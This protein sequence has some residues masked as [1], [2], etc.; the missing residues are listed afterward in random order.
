M[1]RRTRTREKRERKR[2]SALATSERGNRFYDNRAVRSTFT[3]RANKRSL[4]ATDFSHSHALTS[5]RQ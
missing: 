3:P 5:Y 1:S 4:P 2:E